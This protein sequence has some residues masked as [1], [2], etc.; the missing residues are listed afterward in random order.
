MTLAEGTGKTAS[1]HDLRHKRAFDGRRRGPAR[2]CGA[3][4]TSTCRGSA[5]AGAARR[6]RR[7]RRAPHAAPRHAHGRDHH[8]RAPR[9]PAPHAPAAA[10]DRRVRLPAR[11]HAGLPA[12]RVGG[13]GRDVHVRHA[14]DPRHAPAPRAGPGHRAGGRVRG[15]RGR[16][17]RHADRPR[18]ARVRD[19]AAVRRP[20]RGALT[21]VLSDGL[22]RGDPAQM[23]AAVQRLARLSHQLSWWSPLAL[24]PST[25]RSRAPWRR[26]SATSNWPARGTSRRCLKGCV[27][28]ERI[29]RRPSPH[30]A[31]AG[32]AVAE[33]ADDPAHLRPLR[34]A[35]DA[36][37]P[38][39]RVRRL[40][41]RARLHPVRLH[42]GQLAAGPLGRR[43]RV[44][45]EPA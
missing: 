37:L 41:R 33:R 15:G 24:H 44:G 11:A 16:G 10:A 6:G 5:R 9:A 28:C 45:A 22:E 20:R 30:L 32:P 27:N 36:G 8:A 25:G 4:S 43:G 3:R 18:A 17:Q 19:H 26:S 38:R 39:G 21:I 12:L 35:A 14:P 31:G 1:V 42:A 13:A 2:S 40:R 29:R 7:D 34:G 23:V